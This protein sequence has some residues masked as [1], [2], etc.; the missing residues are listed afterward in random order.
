MT[1]KFNLTLKFMSWLPLKAIGTLTKVFYIFG[2]NLVILA[3]MGPELSH[4]QASDWHTDWHT[5]G[6]IHTQAQATAIP[7][8]QNL[9]RV[10]I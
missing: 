10:K 3:W 8:G 2:S 1:F 7:D 5:H 4:R 6:H 9:P